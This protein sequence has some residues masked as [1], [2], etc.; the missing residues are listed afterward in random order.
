MTELYKRERYQSLQGLEREALV[1]ISE[2]GRATF[3]GI[4]AHFPGLSAGTMEMV[5]QNLMSDGFIIQ[6]GFGYYCT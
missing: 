6:N 4:H 1:V 5:L 3:E 2:K